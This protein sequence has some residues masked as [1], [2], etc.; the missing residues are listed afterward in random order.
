MMD[1]AHVAIQGAQLGVHT[2]TIEE[3]GKIERIQQ[4]DAFALFRFLVLISSL[5]HGTEEIRHGRTLK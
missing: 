4:A 5:R 1:K 3:N 2:L